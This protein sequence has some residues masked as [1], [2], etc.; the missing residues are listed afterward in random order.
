MLNP[1]LKNKCA[2]ALLAALRLTELL[3]I[4]HP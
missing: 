4:E 1:H 2:T 3:N